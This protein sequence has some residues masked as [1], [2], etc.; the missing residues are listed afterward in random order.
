MLNKMCQIFAWMNRLVTRL[1]GLSKKLAG[2]NPRSEIR[3]GSIRVAINNIR[4]MAIR[5]H[6]TVGLEPRYAITFPIA[7]IWGVKPAN[8]RI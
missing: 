2:C 6:T 7:D 3:S 5:S 8:Y 4:F 1:Q